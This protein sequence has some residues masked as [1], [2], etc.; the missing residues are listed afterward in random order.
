MCFSSLISSLCILKCDRLSIS[1]LFYVE[2]VFQYTMDVFFSAH[3]LVGFGVSSA[4]SSSLCL[5][6]VV[7]C[8]R[9][10]GGWRLG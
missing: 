1:I 4:L 10:C 8:G 3:P 7:L 5:T 2:L 6:L 9:E